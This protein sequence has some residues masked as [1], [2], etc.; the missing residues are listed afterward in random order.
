MQLQICVFCGSS[1][2]ISPIYAEEAARLADALAEAGIGLV[3]GGGGTGLMGV[4]ARTLKNHGG[5]VTGIVPRALDDEQIFN[6]SDVLHVVNSYHERKML[7]YHLS[8]GFVAL[9]GGLGTLEELMEHLTWM[10]RGRSRKPVY[11]INQS[12]YWGPL[13]QMFES[14]QRA[15]FISADLS[16]RYSVCRSACDAISEFVCGAVG[17]VLLSK[18]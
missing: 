1:P 10:H 3:Y 7:M 13:L 9:P 11:I 5:H 2:G 17:S 4:L 6:E 16:S 15:G 12:G 14:M 8:D 18:D